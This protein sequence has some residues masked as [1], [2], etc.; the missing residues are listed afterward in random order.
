[1]DLLDG[2]LKKFETGKNI[3][4]EH[5]KLSKI[6]KFGCKMLHTIE[7]IALRIWQILYTFVLRVENNT[8]L[9][10]LGIHFSRMIE[11]YRKFANFARLYFLL[12]TTFY[13]QT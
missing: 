13:N 12:F 5:P 8:H 6:V 2:I 9:I 1:M 11:N 10:P 7:N 4:K 3:L